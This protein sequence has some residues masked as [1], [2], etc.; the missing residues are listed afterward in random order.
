MSSSAPLVSPVL[1]DQALSLL[2]HAE[3]RGGITMRPGQLP[4]TEV[5]LEPLIRQIDLIGNSLRETMPSRVLLF[6]DESHEF[7]DVIR[8][9]MLATGYSSERAYRITLQAH[10]E[11]CAVAYEGPEDAC[12]RVGAIFERAALKWRLD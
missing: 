8:I 9:V 12:E 11:G 6:N 3:P 1:R 7:T 5:D 2:R 10:T 4:A